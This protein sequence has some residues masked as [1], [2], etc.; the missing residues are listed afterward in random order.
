RVQPR[1]APAPVVLSRPVAGKRL[2]RRELHA[3]RPVGDE[4]LA[5][6]AGRGDPPLQLSNRFAGRIDP[7]GTGLYAAFDG[8]THTD[9]PLN[10]R[11]GFGRLWPTFTLFRITAPAFRRTRRRPW[12]TSR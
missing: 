6:P 4:L 7:E 12:L 9:L 10:T 11:M 1:L 2:D 8:R 3:L 5:G